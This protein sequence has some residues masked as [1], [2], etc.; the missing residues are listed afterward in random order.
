VPEEGI[1]EFDPIVYEQETVET[2]AITNDKLDLKC[3]SFLQVYIPSA[4]FGRAYNESSSIGKQ[5]CD[6]KKPADSMAPQGSDCIED[7]A[8]LLATQTLCHGRGSCSVPVEPDMAVLGASC[9]LLK[10]ELRTEHICG[11]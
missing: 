5:L 4:T 2:C 1:L 8:S 9:A 6:G 10:K 7:S 3:P 11:K